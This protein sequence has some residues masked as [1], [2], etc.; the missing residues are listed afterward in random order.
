MQVNK[1]NL[2]GDTCTLKCN[3]GAIIVI[4][5]FIC[6]SPYKTSVKEKNI[7]WNSWK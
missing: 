3:F 7:F 4:S 6:L 5:I 1:E 2:F